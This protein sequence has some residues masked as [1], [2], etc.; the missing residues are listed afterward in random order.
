MNVL[1]P[2][3]VLPP[4]SAVLLHLTAEQLSEFADM[5]VARTRQTTPATG[6][7]YDDAQLLTVK[8]AGEF[9]GDYSPDIVRRW[10]NEGRAV[11]GTNRVVKLNI[12]PGLD[13]GRERR[14]RVKDLKA[15]L[16]CFPSQRVEKSFLNHHS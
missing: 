3:F 9:A 2:S 10:I 5:V 14:I 6:P 15:F 8:K 13:D 16:A 4:G 11:S 1:P 7:Q 12:V